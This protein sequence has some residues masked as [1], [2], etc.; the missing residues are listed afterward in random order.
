[1]T[2][3]NKNNRRLAVIQD[4]SGLGRCSLAAAL[5]VLSVMGAQ[6]CPVPTA[7][8]TNQTGF[9]RF[10]SLDCEALLREF[11]A[12]WKEHGVALDGIYT[13][14]MSS[15]GQLDA[16]RGFIEA[17][18]TSESLL[19]V[20]PVMGDDGARYPCF[21]D[22]FCRA[23]RSFAARADVITPNVTEA[24]LLTGTPYS[25]FAAQDEEDQLELLRRMCRAL[26]S[27]QIVITGWRRGD[28][29]RI[30]ACGGDG[31]S[32]YE[33][34]NL[35]GSWSGTGDLFASALCGGLLRGDSLDAS[36]RRA[37]RFLE[38]SLADAARLACPKE[39]G[40]PFEPHLKELLT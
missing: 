9:S 7:V 25:F 12:L 33:S 21:D 39:E 32:I 26:P 20:D 6:C 40:V 28:K 2:T 18:R 14:F 5:P 27:K 30:F 29:I 15:V 16:A 1:M 17:F 23:M 22:A 19:V 4:I 31:Y 10:A 37:M 38:A 35:E 8:F 34:P 13:G 24:C 3:M 11:P 36:I